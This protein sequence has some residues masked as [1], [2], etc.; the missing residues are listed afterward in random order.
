[1]NLNPVI[2]LPQKGTRV[3][4]SRCAGDKRL[5]EDFTCW[6]KGFGGEKNSFWPIPLRLLCLF[7]ANSTAV[8]RMNQTSRSGVTQRPIQPF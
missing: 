1:M 6:M 7:V 4:K 8:L 3:T 2:H 5:R